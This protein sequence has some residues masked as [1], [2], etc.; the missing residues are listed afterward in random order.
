MIKTKKGYLQQNDR[1]V[2]KCYMKLSH[3]VS[4]HNKVCVA[5]LFFFFFE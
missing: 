3:K 2:E 4:A 5:K 1:T